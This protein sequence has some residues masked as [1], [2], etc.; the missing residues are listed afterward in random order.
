MKEG[1]YTYLM[2]ALFKPDF[3]HFI[4][5]LIKDKGANIGFETMVGLLFLR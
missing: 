1:K 5:F 3:S 4:D 2:A